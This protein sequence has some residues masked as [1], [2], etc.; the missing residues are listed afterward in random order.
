MHTLSAAEHI[1]GI[2]RARAQAA[3]ESLTHRE[4][5][6]ALL[7][8]SG[9]P[10]TTIATRLKISPKTLDI[11][12]ANICKKMGVPPIGIPRVVLA[13]QVLDMLAAPLVEIATHG[14]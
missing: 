4:R 10:N 11:H 14:A 12:R 8:A 1:F 13:Y 9:V 2:T 5:D 3:I 7:M 6:V